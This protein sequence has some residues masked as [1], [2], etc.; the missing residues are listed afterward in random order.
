MWRVH[1]QGLA[2]STTAN[3]MASISEALGI[4][5]PGS[6][7]SPAESENRRN[8]SEKTGKSISLLI[9]NNIRP[10][11][12]L[13]FEAFENAISIVNA[14]GGSTNA[15][16]HLMAIANELGIKLQI[17]DFERIRKHTPYCR[18]ATRRECVMADLDRIGGIQVAL[19][20]LLS[21]GVLNGNTLTVTGETMRENISLLRGI[22][23]W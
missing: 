22:S 21:L 23:R 3:T 4:S 18:Y 13:S 6:A 17:K 20:K 10:R 8:I 1:P 11:D 16:L 15:V 19:R 5:L 14:I 2:G 9:E 12:I 7:S